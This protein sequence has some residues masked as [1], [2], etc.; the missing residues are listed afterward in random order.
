VTDQWSRAPVGTLTANPGGDGYQCSW[1][2]LDMGEGAGGDFMGLDMDGDGRSEIL[3]RWWGPKGIGLAVYAPTPDGQGYYHRWSSADLGRPAAAVAWL[4]V[5]MNGDG[6]TEIVQLFDT[7]KALGMITWAPTDDGG[8]ASPWRCDDSGEG[9]GGQF[10]AVDGNGDGRTEI[11]QIWPGPNGPAMALYRPT[12]DGRGYAKTWSS[13]ELGPGSGGKFFCVDAEADGRT[14]ILHV[15]PG[16][17]G[18]AMT[19][20]SPT[21]GDGYERA[22][23]STDLGQEAGAVAWLPLDTT[24]DGETELAQLWDTGSGLGLHVWSPTTTGAGAPACRTSVHVLDPTGTPM[25]NTP[26]TVSADRPALLLLGGSHRLVGP[27]VPTQVTTDGRGTATI[28]A[29]ALGLQSA[30]LTLE[31]GGAQTV[32]N[33]MRNVYD[34]LAGSRAR[35]GNQFGGTA[36]DLLEARDALNRPLPLPARANPLLAGDV[37]EQLANAGRMGTGAEVEGGSIVL[38]PPVGSTVAR[39]PRREPP[40]RSTVTLAGGRAEGFPEFWKSVGDHLGDL[41]HG[42]EHEVI[43]VA[44]AVV[45]WTE[46]RWNLA[47]NAANDTFGSSPTLNIVLHDIQDV[48]HAAHL[49]LSWLGAQLEWLLSWGSD[50]LDWEAY[51]LAAEVGEHLADEIVPCAQWLLGEGRTIADDLI[52]EAQALMD[53]GIDRIVASYGDLTVGQALALQFSSLPGEPSAGGAGTSLPSLPPL[54]SAARHNWLIE[55]LLGDQVRLGAEV[56]LDAHPELPAVLEAAAAKLETPQVEAAAARLLARLDDL[57]G[58]TQQ[59]L[60]ALTVRELAATVRGL[61]DDAVTVATAGVDAV[62][63]GAAALVGALPSVDTAAIDLPIIGSA[64]KQKDSGSEF[65]LSSIFAWVGAVAAVTGWKLAYGGGRPFEQADVDAIKK[66][67]VFP[68]PTPVPAQGDPSDH[69]GLV[70]LAAVLGGMGGLITAVSDQVPPS[71]SAPPGLSILG[72]ANDIFTPALLGAYGLWSASAESAGGERSLGLASG[73]FGVLEG[74]LNFGWTA[75]TGYRKNK[76][77]PETAFSRNLLNRSASARFFT[78]GTVVNAAYGVVQL[79]TWAII[80]APPQDSPPS[81]GT[82]MQAGAYPIAA[83][84]GPLR[85]LYEAQPEIIPLVVLGIDTAAIVVDTLGYTIDA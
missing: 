74:L 44:D 49:A 83:V 14:E 52:G 24:G 20:F 51:R 37:A 59:Q 82:Q 3:Q 35:E 70:V 63:A 72:T 5:D 84:L 60:T 45:S 47:V 65:K 10:L 81:A 7:G 69:D 46:T 34:F 23:E 67:L 36:A 57:S 28:Y 43:Q 62:F 1:T 78:S 66:T 77:S 21:A 85:N 39:L 13:A 75:L 2:S 9:A 8:Y 50:L 38:R 11:V 41:V 27:G 15:Y 26:V 58:L 79:A 80:A 68:P 48:G 4:P 6:R 55:K 71:E 22:W 30:S 17:S 76:I 56:S 12:D 64:L 73:V 42:A 33:P 61:A 18:V 54:L 25:P 29:P 32:V 16:P 19:L 53:Q 31:C 40:S